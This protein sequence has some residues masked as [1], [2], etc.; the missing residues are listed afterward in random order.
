M[1]MVLAFILIVMASSSCSFTPC[2]IQPPVYTGGVVPPRIKKAIYKMGP[3]KD[4]KFH[5]DTATLYVKVDGEW[6]KLRY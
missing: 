1:K 5:H 6:L 3:M 2:I 4:Y